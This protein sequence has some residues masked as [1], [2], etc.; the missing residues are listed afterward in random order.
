MGCVEQHLKGGA[1]RRWISVVVFAAF[2]GLASALPAQAQSFELTDPSNP[3][4]TVA[5]D[6]TA[7]L[8]AKLIAPTGTQWWPGSRVA[9][10]RGPVLPALYGSLIILQ[11]YDGYSTNRGL[12][13]GAVES[14]ALMASLAKHPASLWAVKGGAAFVSIY[15]A[16]RLW[17]QHRRGQ[18]LAVM[19]VSNALM[20]GVASSNAA[21]VRN[22]K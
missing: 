17:R 9:A 1:V 6:T 14:N 12:R 5:P 16:E 2:A 7:P 15:M 19:V 20:V 3:F 8:Y 10:S 4:L 13:N 18:A 22:L 11:A 21:I